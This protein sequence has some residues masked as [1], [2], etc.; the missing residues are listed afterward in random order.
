MA[1]NRKGRKKPVVTVDSTP[2][3]KSQDKSQT[4]SARQERREKAIEAARI[5]RQQKWLIIGALIVTFIAFWNSLDGEFVYDDQLQILKN[6]TIKTISNIPV[7]FTE[8]VW[9]FMNPADREATGPYYRPLFNIAL[10]INYQ[11]FQFTVIGWHLFSVFIHL[12]VT[13]LVYLLARRWGL[14][15]EVAVAAALIFGVHPVHSESVAWVAALP[16]PMAGVFLLASLLLYEYHF[17]KPD[18]KPLI[19]GLSLAAAFFALL[20]KEVSVVFPVFLIIRELLDKSQSTSIRD[21]IIRTAKRTAPFFAVVAVYMALRYAVLG[22]INQNEPTSVNIPLSHVL[23]TVPSIILSYLRMLVLPYPLAVMYGNT[24]VESASD[25][26][27][28]ASALTVAAIAI[29]VVWMVRSSQAGLRS[30]VWMTLF[31]LP[32]LNLKAFRAYESLI[33]DRYL[34]LPSIG[35]CILV[36]MAL[37]WIAQHFAARQRE[38]LRVAAAIV[39]LPMLVLTINQNATWQNEIAMTDQALKVTPNWPFLYNYIGAYHFQQNRMAEAERAYNEALKINPNYFDSL[40][41]LGDIYRTQGKLGDAEQLYLKAIDAGA[42]YPTTYYN[43]GVVY[44]EQRRLSEAEW[45]L[46]K[47]IELEP[48]YTKALYNLGWVYDNQGK[49]REAE[50]TYLQTLQ[51]DPNYVE[52]RINLGVILTK[53]QRYKEA[54]DQLT[55]A[56]RLQPDHPVMLYALGDVYM[57]TERYQEAV[58]YFNRLIAREPRHRIAHTSL[59]LCYEKLG[60]I[61]QAKAHFQK[62]IEIAPQDPYTNL[63]RERLAKL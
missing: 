8:S 55:Y 13:F 47:A 2:S 19:Y 52:P 33:H 38:A 6:P 63:A 58:N 29:A 28:W 7:M 9:Q 51:Y 39:V 42:P 59:G 44:T 41:N 36:A 31:L 1:S 62:A 14:A 49:A 23:L 57:K 10:I 17:N 15:Q 60:Q 54:L 22:F 24:Y 40:S 4:Q 30:L 20:C 18:S 32:V 21:T 5:S 35:F 43:L 12:L 37:G 11:M 56:Q 46:Q 45:P 25:P 48:G 53:Q 16:D 27:F 34:Y 50:Q 3:D 26:R 61:D